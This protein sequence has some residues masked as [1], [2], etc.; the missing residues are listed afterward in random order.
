VAEHDHGP[1]GALD[2]IPRDER[3]PFELDPFSFPSETRGR[4]RMLV[5][6]ALAF[7]WSLASWWIQIPNLYTRAGVEPEVQAAFDRFRESGDPSAVP[8]E[9]V[10]TFAKAESTQKTLRILLFHTIRL[11]LSLAFLTIF[12]LG[13]LA[14]YRLHPRLLRRRHRM[15]PISSTTAKEE[16]RRLAG[17][18]GLATEP[19]LECKPGLLD[20]LAFGR[21]KQETLALAGSPR[22]L[23]GTWNDLTR[24]VA[25]HEMGH[26]VNEDVRNREVTRAMW[27]VL[28][29][30]VALQ[31][32]GVALAYFFLGEMRFPVFQPAAFGGGPTVGDTAGPMSTVVKT[33]VSFFVVWWIWA[34]LIRAREHYADYRV[35]LWGFK[36]PLLLL[37]QLPDTSRPWWRRFPLAQRS[38][39]ACRSRSWWGPWMRFWEKYGWRRHPSKAARAHAL[40][41]GEVL[42]QAGPDLA[43]LT[44]ILLALLAAQMT[45][46]STDLTLLGVV[47]GAALFVLVGPF[48]LLV[49]LG[50]GLA[51]T[52]LVT[53]LVTSALGIQIQRQAVA[54]LATRP[55]NEWGYLRLGKTALFFAL[56]LEA[57]LL[58][59]P[60][61][62]TA[63]ARSPGWTLAWFFGFSLLIWLWLLYLRSTTRLFLGTQS[64]SLLP[65]WIRRWLSGTSMLLLTA[66]LWPAL[67]FR[68]AIEAGGRSDLL[69]AMALGSVSPMEFFATMFLATSLILF[70][71]GLTLYILT[72]TLCV[73]VA[74]ARMSKPRRC[75]S[76]G[77]HVPYKLVIGRQCPS[78]HTALATWLFSD[79]PCR[80][81]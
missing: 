81:T 73:I 23:E 57:G 21:Y 3:P 13:T 74:I 14:L 26:I 43:F 4:F 2:S 12:G 66:L 60:L 64:G 7:T 27:T 38:Y 53:W 46:L 70:S 54:D 52:W 79:S 1:F 22:L 30:L 39:E 19:H 80:G 76:C 9:D 47:L 44:G 10:E 20:G 75:S 33:A 17:R 42:F 40:R 65:K 8:R 34:G 50:I 62:P 71:L 31:A 55:H 6:A 78:C 29:V 69:A 61:S 67:G 25:L 16:V 72:M 18:A 5:A 24:A 37:L 36:K 56:G 63:A 48:A 45:S 32:A 59:S 15:L 58:I 68:L 49:F 41:E 11:A 77:E 51:V 28:P 35:S